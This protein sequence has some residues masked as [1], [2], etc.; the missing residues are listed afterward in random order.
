MKGNPP[1][2]SQARIGRESQKVIAGVVSLACLFTVSTTLFSNFLWLGIAIAGAVLLL[3]W[4]VL[5]MTVSIESQD[6]HLVIRC[7]PFYSK[8]IP[9]KDIVDVSHAPSSSMTEGFGI[10]YLGRKTWGV[11]SGGPAITIETPDRIWIV[12]TPD[13]ESASSAIRA[14][15][16]PK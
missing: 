14:L 1:V 7:R 2:I 15:T 11:L 8:T 10:R 9:L 4:L 6:D 16:V 3:M 5:S 13:P 12:S